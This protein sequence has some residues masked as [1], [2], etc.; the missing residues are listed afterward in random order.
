VVTVG[1]E[2]G[3]HDLGRA[4]RTGSRTIRPPRLNR[5]NFPSRLQLGASNRPC[6]W[7][8]TRRSPEGIRTVS[9]VLYSVGCVAPTG[10]ESCARRRVQART[11][12]TTRLAKI[13]F[14]NTSLQRYSGRNNSAHRLSAPRLL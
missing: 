1:S 7:Y 4:A 10:V 12:M 2:S 3:I 14:N 5:N 8:T 9:S 6:A 11:V 13:F